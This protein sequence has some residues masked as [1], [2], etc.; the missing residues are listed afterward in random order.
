MTDGNC[1]RDC[2]EDED[3][4]IQTTCEI[5]CE[6]VHPRAPFFSEWVSVELDENLII[7]YSKRQNSLPVT[8]F[9]IDIGK[10]CMDSGSQV[11]VNAYPT[12]LSKATSCPLEPVNDV[13]VDPRFTIHD[14]SENLE[15]T[16]YDMFREHNLL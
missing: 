2:E 15:F 6:E 10:P 8:T 5:Y 16:E 4:K 9:G 7:R 3:F 14:K 13:T 1:F 11:H 12:E